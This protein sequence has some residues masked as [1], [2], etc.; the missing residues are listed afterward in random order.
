MTRTA[1]LL[2]M[3]VLLAVAVATSPE[4]ATSSPV[5]R[6][7]RSSTSPSQAR[8]GIHKIRHV[9]IVVQENRSFDNYF[10]AYRGAAEAT[11][12]TGRL[13]P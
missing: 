7:Q 2:A 13:L 6:A 1:G 5:D 8:R 3:A 9:V 4:S 12:Q 11:R 10:G